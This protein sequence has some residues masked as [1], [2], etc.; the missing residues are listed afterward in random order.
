MASADRDTLVALYNATDGANWRINTNWNTDA[1]LSLWHGIQVDDQGRVVE[2]KLNGI[3][4]R[5]ILRFS[6]SKRVA[7]LRCV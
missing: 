4:L 5:G 7:V 6:P 1:D 3:N 2:L